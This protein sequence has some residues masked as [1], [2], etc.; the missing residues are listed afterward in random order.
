MT[1]YTAGGI[2]EMRKRAGAGRTLV[3]PRTCFAVAT[4]DSA[5]RILPLRIWTEI[6]EMPRAHLAELVRRLSKTQYKCGAVASQRALKTVDK[7]DG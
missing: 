1:A 5:E 3:N 7:D 6:Q 4:E 2:A